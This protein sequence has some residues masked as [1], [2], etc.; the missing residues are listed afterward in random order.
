MSDI[1]CINKNNFANEDV[2]ACLSQVA[3]TSYDPKITQ[4]AK[5]WSYMPKKKQTQM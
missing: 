3:I 4:G 2:T 1:L 5:K